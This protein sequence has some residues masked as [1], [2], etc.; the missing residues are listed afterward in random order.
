MNSMETN[1]F[2]TVIDLKIDLERL[3]FNFRR[4]DFRTTFEKLLF[5]AASIN[6]RSILKV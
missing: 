3:Y 1:K 4:E 2:G 6:T 5:Y